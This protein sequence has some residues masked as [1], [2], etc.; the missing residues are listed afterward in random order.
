MHLTHPA[1]Q[2][3]GWDLNMEVSLGP[4]RSG[5][6][7]ADTRRTALDGLMTICHGCDTEEIGA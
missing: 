7:R 3:G 5:R 6:G 1:I 4:G 2:G